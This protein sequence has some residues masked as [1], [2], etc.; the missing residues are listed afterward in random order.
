MK[1]STKLEREM[2]EQ[3]IILEKYGGD[4]TKKGSNELHKL[5]NRV[6]P[7]GGRFKLNTPKGYEEFMDKALEI[8]KKYDLPTKF[9]P[10]NF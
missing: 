10:I 3:Y 5:L 7:V 4:I 1:G 2:Y 8:A 9:D 6:N